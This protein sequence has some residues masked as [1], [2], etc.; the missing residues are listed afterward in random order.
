MIHHGDE[1]VQQHHDI[2]DRICAEHEHAPES[3]EY[4]DAVQLKAVQIHQSEYRP[5]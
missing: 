2:D 4:F 1:Q 3:G 5:K